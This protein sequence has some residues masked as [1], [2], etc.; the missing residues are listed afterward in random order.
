MTFYAKTDTGRTRTLNEDCCGSSVSPDRACAFF[1]VADGMGGQKAGEVASS[2]AIS[3]L[4][5]YF[6]GFFDHF[7]YA[8]GG[9]GA[10]CR[11]MHDAVMAANQ[12]IL[13]RASEEDCKGMG[14]TLVCAAVTPERLMVANVGDSR[15]Y[16]ISDGKGEQLTVDHSFVEDLVREGHIDR[17]EART[18]PRRN[19]ITRALGTDGMMQEDLFVYNYRPGDILLLCS[20]GLTKMVEDE[21]IFRIAAGTG[22]AKLVCERLVNCANR[23]GGTDN[24]TVVAVLL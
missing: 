10:V 20:D 19:E 9:E 24:I 13:S 12:A 11:T 4:T 15:A 8:R 1:M 17:T 7:T 14:T 23:N 3:T 5:A 21:E 22:D 16:L 18:H 6:D 2:I